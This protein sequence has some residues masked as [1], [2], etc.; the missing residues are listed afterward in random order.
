MLKII[1][2]AYFCN[3]CEFLLCR[4]QMVSRS[5]LVILKSIYV[6]IANVGDNAR[7]LLGEE[8]IKKLDDLS[9]GLYFE[10]YGFSQDTFG[11]EFDLCKEILKLRPLTIPSN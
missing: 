2:D 3:F 11:G 6:A 4:S 8:L 1:D 7:K 9:Y 5:E 10:N